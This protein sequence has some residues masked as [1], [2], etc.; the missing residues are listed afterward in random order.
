M[1]IDY[2]KKLQV[3]QLPTRFTN[4]LY[5][6]LQY[7]L[8]YPIDTLESIILFGSCARQDVR[9]TSDVD[10]LLITTTPLDRFTRGEI[11]S[12]LEE[13]LDKVH[14][15]IIFYTREQFEQSERLIAKQIKKEGV[16]LYEK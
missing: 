7:L 12:T 11:S 9:L 14:T 8:Q 15:D 13:D 4:K 1:G 5:S 3:L 2:R 16:I 6:D 10:I